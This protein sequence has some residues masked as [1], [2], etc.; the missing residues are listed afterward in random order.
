MNPTEFSLRDKVAIVTGGSRGIGRAIAL[1]F[2]KVGARVV[3]A[4]RTPSALDEVAREIESLGG[5]AVAVVA[6]VSISKDVD[7]LVERALEAFGRI[8]IL[9]NNAG[10]SPIYKRAETVSEEEWDRIIEVNLKGVFLCCQAVGK[11]MI[12]Q[13]GGVI[14]NMVS[15]GAEVGLPRLIAYC[16]AKGG[17]EQITKVLALEWAKH[18][19]R[20]NAIGPAYV[21]TDLTA[22]LRANPR[23]H[24]MIVEQ[25]PL[26][27]MAKPEEIV[28][29]A[30]FLASD[31]SSYVTGQTIYVDGGWMA[32]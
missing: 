22:G 9:V 12:E 23:L 24:A 13:K 16:A 28:G 2:A 31:A 17:V 15:V 7:H 14:I 8:D 20:V 10:I 6:D 21:E 26:G 27:R 11:V 32:R 25:T 5:R 19:I 4:S 29:A 18:N 3:I 30:I 1:G